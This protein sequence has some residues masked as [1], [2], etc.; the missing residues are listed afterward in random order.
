M[1]ML[2]V[3]RLILF[4][5]C[6]IFLLTLSVA[7]GR[8]DLLD[9]IDRDKPVNL[10]FKEHE[11]ELDSEENQLACTE[12]QEDLVQLFRELFNAP[13]DMFTELDKNKPVNLVF[14]KHE[15]ELDSEQ[16]Q[17][18]CIITQE[19]FVYLIREL[20]RKAVWEKINRKEVK[21]YH[22]TEGLIGLKTLF[23]REPRIQTRSLLR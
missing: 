2:S 4:T 20:S 15:C 13:E 16:S 12:N 1:I 9:T 11:C 7:F 14:K 23:L 8:E 22:N 17:M 21:L 6:L 3:L 19:Q 18:V 5:G 10:V